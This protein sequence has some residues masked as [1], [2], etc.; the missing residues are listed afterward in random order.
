MHSLAWQRAKTEG[1]R[2]VNQAKVTSRIEATPKGY[3]LLKFEPANPRRTT[4]SSWDS[5]PPN[6]SAWRKGS[7]KRW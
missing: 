4:L 3:G 1:E 2:D 7:E 5:R 6:T